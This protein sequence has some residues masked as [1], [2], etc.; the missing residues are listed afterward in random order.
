M[1]SGGINDWVTT[2]SLHKVY[3][4]G[5][6]RILGATLWWTRASYKR[7]S[8]NAPG[9]FTLPLRPNG[10]REHNNIHYIHTEKY[11]PK[12]YV[13]NFR[14][15]ISSSQSEERTMVFTREKNDTSN[16]NCERCFFTCEKNDTSNQKPLFARGVWVLRQNSRLL[17][18]L[19]APLRTHSTRKVLLK[20]FFSLKKWKTFRKWSGIVSFVSLSMKKTVESRRNNS[21]KRKTESDVSFC[22]AFCRSYFAFHLSLS[23]YWNR[24]FTYTFFILIL[25]FWVRDCVPT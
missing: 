24:H 21:G 5:H 18:Q 20:E 9:S 7:R 13:V 3:K 25:I 22:C 1:P 2:L 16:Q 4:W 11:S 8:S 14:T 10:P 6:G 15:Q 12:N 17:L 23:L 19:A